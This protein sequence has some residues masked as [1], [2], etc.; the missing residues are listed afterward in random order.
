[1]FSYH[2]KEKIR[3]VTVASMLLSTCTC[4]CVAESVMVVHILSCLVFTGTYT[5]NCA[6][7]IVNIPLNASKTYWFRN[8]L[9]KI[10]GSR[11]MEGHT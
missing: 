8:T 1:M 7:N 9:T 3:I 2:F 10:S 4:K 11:A 6:K 5:D